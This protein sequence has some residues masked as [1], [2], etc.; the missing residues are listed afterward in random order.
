M[1]EFVLSRQAVSSGLDRRW[2]LEEV[3]QKWSEK[4]RDSEVGL[5]KSPRTAKLI[6]ET[7]Q[8]IRSFSK[9]LKE[10]IAR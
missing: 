2:Q 10:R 7:R 1:H 3:K 6:M 5:V 9:P 8:V 4:V